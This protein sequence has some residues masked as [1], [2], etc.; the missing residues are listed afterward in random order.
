VTGGYVVRDPRLTGWQGRYLYGDFCN[1]IVR[2]ARLGPR[3]ASTRR[4]TGL[5]VD[6]L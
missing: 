6:N 3:G 4:P 2:S 1:G 5:H